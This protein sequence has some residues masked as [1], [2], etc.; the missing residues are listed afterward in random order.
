M[1][2]GNT[3]LG[4]KDTIVIVDHIPAAEFHNG[5]RI[6][7]IDGYLFI[8]TGDATKPELAQDPH[9]WPAR[10]YVSM[11]MVIQRRVILSVQ[12]CMLWV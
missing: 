12:D 1:I 7:M 11:L 3:D 9:P 8:T 2:I 6:K 4:F 10:F 5:G